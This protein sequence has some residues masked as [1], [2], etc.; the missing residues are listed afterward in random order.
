MAA[1]K[2]L[3]CFRYLLLTL[4]ASPA[5]QGDWLAENDEC[6][7]GTC[8][9]QALQLSGK[10]RY[11]DGPHPALCDTAIVEETCTGVNKLTTEYYNSTADRSAQVVHAAELSE[12][13][14]VSRRSV[15]AFLEGL[16]LTNK[17]EDPKALAR[18][19]YAVDCVEL[20][21]AVVDSIPSAR[22]PPTSDIACYIPHGQTKAVCDIDVSDTALGAS[23]RSTLEDNLPAEQVYGEGSQELAKRDEANTDMAKYKE[24]LA[25]ETATTPDDLAV[26]DAL[27]YPEAT[28]DAIRVTI[29]NLFRIYPLNNIQVSSAPSATSLLETARANWQDQVQKNAIRAQAYMATATRSITT[30]KADDELARW[31]GKDDVPTKK[32][33]RRLLNQ[34]DQLLSN[35]DYV[36]PG[37]QCTENRF[38]YVIPNPPH[39][40]NERG[41]YLFYL[42]DKYMNVDSAEQVETLVHEGSHHRMS[43]RDDVC[44]EGS[45]SDCRVAYGRIACQSLAAKDPK[46]ALLN[47]DNFAFFVNDVQPNPQLPKCPTAKR[48]TADPTCA[49][50]KGLYQK[51]VK[52]TTGAVCYQCSK[53]KPVSNGKKKKKHASADGLCETTNTGGTC[54]LFLCSRT[55]GPTS[56]SG[57]QCI[58]NAG[59]CAEDGYC[60]PP[61]AGVLGSGPDPSQE[62]CDVKTGGSCKFLWCWHGRGPTVCKDGQCICREGYCSE[63][64]NCKP[65]LA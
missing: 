55:R 61:R 63:D 19:A 52:T 41:Q 60:M 65:Q 3:R 24:L 12:Q 17:E 30:A 2:P 51:E 8:A 40:M 14:M 35:V 7:D 9:L 1:A 20:C 47:A 13:M 39:N 50:D 23:T 64:G 49:C 42:C 38:A 48:C 31:F 27:D 34:V 11:E 46:S 58:C 21:A 44:L 5:A 59:L 6:Q 32:E 25:N 4:L 54:K 10:K 43:L 18:K 15:R 37:S 28:A 53:D 22:R 26:L 33:V 45:G 57:G 56:C 29:A 36:Y 62:G 16:G